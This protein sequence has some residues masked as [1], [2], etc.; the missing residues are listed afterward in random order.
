[1]RT[2]INHWRKN[3]KV[4]GCQADEAPALTEQLD[5]ILKKAEV[6][7]PNL[8]NQLFELLA[9]GTALATNLNAWF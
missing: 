3:P 5:L 2:S 4:S 1:M 6:A 9:N 8:T 7:L